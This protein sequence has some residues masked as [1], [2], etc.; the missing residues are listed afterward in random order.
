[1][2]SNIEAEVNN[3]PQKTTFIDNRNME[4]EPTNRNQSRPVIN[5]LVQSVRDMMIEE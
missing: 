4:R 3:F 1:M 2:C 5:A